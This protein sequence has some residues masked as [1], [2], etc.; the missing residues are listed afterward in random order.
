MKTTI[1]IP[2]TTNDDGP[3]RELLALVDFSKKHPDKFDW[4]KNLNPW[5]VLF[6]D[7]IV[8]LSRNI[9]DLRLTN[10]QHEKAKE[11]I[12]RMTLI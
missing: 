2:T 6:A 4:K 5:Q 11:C 7:Y 12:A 10:K 1:T 3:L 8:A 9:H